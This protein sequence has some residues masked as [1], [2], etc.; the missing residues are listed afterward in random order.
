M[1]GAGLVFCDI[2]LLREACAYVL[3]LK[4][5]AVSSSRFF[6]VCVFSMSLGCPSG[7][8]SVRH[9]YFYSRFKVALSAYLN[10]L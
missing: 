9:I 2:F 6:S 3:V 8:G 5:T 10:C 4:G 7:F 1:D